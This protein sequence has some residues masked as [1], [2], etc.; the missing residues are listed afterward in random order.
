V[1]LNSH[2]KVSYSTDN[3]QAST[4]GNATV[5]QEYGSSFISPDDEQ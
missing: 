5:A 3:E 4:E 1:A 2:Q